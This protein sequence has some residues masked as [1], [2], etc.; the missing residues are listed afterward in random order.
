MKEHIERQ[1]L[2]LQDKIRKRKI[3]AEKVKKE[4]AD[5]KQKAKELA[6]S[7]E[8]LLTTVQERSEVNQSTEDMH[9]Q[10]NEE[11]KLREEQTEDGINDRECESDQSDE[12]PTDQRSNF[13]STFQDRED[14]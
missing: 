3:E 14:S 6:V 8:S 5:R 13:D 10:Q 1:R 7:K 11:T 9:D 2:L 4:E 12:P